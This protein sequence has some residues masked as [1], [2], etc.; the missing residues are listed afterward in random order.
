[1]TESVGRSS[2]PALLG[3]AAAMQF[4]DAFKQDAFFPIQ[5]SVSMLYPTYFLSIKIVGWVELAELFKRRLSSP[6][7]NNDQRRKHACE[8]QQMDER[9]QN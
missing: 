1:M 9:S 3:F 5:H 7:R 2:R 6:R 4:Y 8:T